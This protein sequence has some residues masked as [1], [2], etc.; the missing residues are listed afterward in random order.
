MSSS[1]EDAFAYVIANEKRIRALLLK[2]ARGDH[3]CADEMFSDVVLERLPRLFELYDGVRP[4]ENY[5]LNNIRWYA[6]K[7][8]NKKHKR[9]F[10]SLEFV[11]HKDPS[12]FLD[13]LEYLNEM[14]RYLVEAVVFYRMS[15]REIAVHLGRPVSHVSA[16]IHHVFEK[17]RVIYADE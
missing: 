15:H 5:M 2:V 7:Y 6:F 9:V 17:L 4:I 10:E 12:S 16:G 13:A 14:E 3:N 1:N 11:K 8:V